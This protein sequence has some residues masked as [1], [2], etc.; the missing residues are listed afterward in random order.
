MAQ[1]D[2]EILGYGTDGQPIVFAPSVSPGKPITLAEYQQAVQQRAGMSAPR[3]F[4]DSAAKAAEMFAGGGMGAGVAGALLPRAGNPMVAGRQTGVGPARIPP[5]QPGARVIPEQR[6]SGPPEIPTYTPE[7]VPGPT[8]LRAFS[9][10]VTNMPP[11][12]TPARPSAGLPAPNQ[13]PGLPAPTPPPNMPPSA[14]SFRDPGGL[15]VGQVSQMD[16]AAAGLASGFNSAP[17]VP[18]WAKAAGAAGAALGGA[19]LAGRDSG[20]GQAGAGT[21]PWNPSDLGVPMADAV[22]RLRAFAQQPSPGAAPTATPPPVAPTTGPQ[23]G[24]TRPM[25]G[26]RVAGGGAGAGVAGAVGGQQA[27]GGSGFAA[28]GGASPRAQA[29]N[30]YSDMLGAADSG[31]AYARDLVNLTSQARQVAYKAQQEQKHLQFVPLHDMRNNRLFLVNANGQDVVLDLNDEG[32]KAAFGRMTAKIGMDPASIMAWAQG[33]SRPLHRY[34]V[35][36]GSQGDWAPQ[37]GQPG[38]A[39]QVGAADSAEPTASQAPFE[40]PQVPRFD[41]GSPLP[42]MRGLNVNADRPLD[43]NMAEIQAIRDQG[44]GGRQLDETERRLRELRATNPTAYARG[45]GG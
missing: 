27:Q 19:Y 14:R 29:A 25:G 7:V 12:Q 18:G 6:L 11:M 22:N 35:P 10:R 28:G 44:L 4:M 40:L 9:G 32:D 20:S 37:F 5:S 15:D 41:A 33:S 17:M 31:D 21:F 34:M 16:A 39:P 2:Y 23:R 8:G 38:T 30:Y 43:A 26:H 3:R 36:P 13:A 1:K 42:T 45:L 24:P